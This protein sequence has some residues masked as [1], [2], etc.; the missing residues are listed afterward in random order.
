MHR[1]FIVIAAIITFI[2]FPTNILG[3][4]TKDTKIIKQTVP[5]LVF[6]AFIMLPKSLNV[7]IGNG[8]R[9]QGDTKWMLYSQII[10]SLFVITCS[11][12]LIKLFHLNIIA[13]YI[14][15]LLDETIRAGI[16]YWHY[17]AH[18]KIVLV[19]ECSIYS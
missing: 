9:A 19:D 13:I 18:S 7:V 15:L 16:N 12:T 1:F 6:T 3:I 4:F 8:I 10:G 17:A 5:F 2:L 14:T 11:C